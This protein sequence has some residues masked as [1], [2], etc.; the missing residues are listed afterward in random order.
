MVRIPSFF[1]AEAPEAQYQSDVF[2]RSDR[3]FERFGSKSS[4]LGSF[5]QVPGLFFLSCFATDVTTMN[6]AV[7][8]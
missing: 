8:V 2:V 6:H 5:P 1:L 3:S 4:R 7:I